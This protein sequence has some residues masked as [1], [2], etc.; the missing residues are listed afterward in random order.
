MSLVR[1]FVELGETQAEHLRRRE[2]ELIALLR[3]ARKERR[4]AIQVVAGTPRA[5]ELEIDEH[6]DPGFLRAG[7][8]V[9][10]RDDSRDGSFGQARLVAIEEVPRVRDGHRILRVRAWRHGRGDAPVT[11]VA[12]QTEGTAPAVAAIAR[13]MRR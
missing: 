6:G 8:G 11:T 12:R 4:L 3:R 1:G 2:R 5:G 13:K 7:T 10:G 9:I